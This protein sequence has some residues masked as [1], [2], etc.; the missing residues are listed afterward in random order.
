MKLAIE[1]YEGLE[2]AAP[3][4]DDPDKFTGIETPDRLAFALGW[5]AANV[6]IQRRYRRCGIDALPIY[7]PETGWDRF[8]LTRRVTSTEFK[9]E[10][11]NSYG[12]IMLDGEDAPRLTTPGGKTILSMGQGMRDDPI[13]T[14]KAMLKRIPRDEMPEGKHGGRWKQRRKVYP[15]LFR[16]ITETLLEH[17]GMVAA[18]EIFVDDKP[19]EGA[20]H[21]LYLHGAALEPKILYDW[22]MV[23]LGRWAV[24]FRTH[25]GQTIYE[26]ERRTWSTVKKQIADEESYEEIKN[27]LEGFLRIK[28]EML[29][30]EKK[31]VSSARN[32]NQKRSPRKKKDDDDTTEK[33]VNTEDEVAVAEQPAAEN[34]EDTEVQEDKS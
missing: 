2:A 15:R 5:I 20:Y 21:P 24:F 13:A 7:H 11:A 25:G 33:L 9:D 27:R 12:M 23:Q 10:P 3:N 22:T 30:E 18:R 31:K 16:A 26:T 32:K 1:N 17:P 8:L 19:I 28:P 34:K 14:L 6:V 29:E 4:P